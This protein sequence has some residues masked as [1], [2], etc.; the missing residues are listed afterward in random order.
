MSATLLP[1]MT[2]QPFCWPALRRHACL[3]RRQD[4]SRVWKGLRVSP[5][6]AIVLE[7]RLGRCEAQGMLDL[8]LPASMP[9]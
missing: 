9:L 4:L 7:D 3:T 2:W 1:L 5:A 6:V 8:V